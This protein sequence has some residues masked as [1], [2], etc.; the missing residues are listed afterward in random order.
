MDKVKIPNEDVIKEL[1]VQFVKDIRK[2]TSDDPRIMA[3]II[4]LMVG[5][6]VASGAVSGEELVNRIVGHLIEND[7]IQPE[8]ISLEEIAA[9][10]EMPDK[11]FLN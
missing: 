5:A 7:M 9:M 2:E 10:Q 8:E 3:S 1:L 4:A 6:T 11:E